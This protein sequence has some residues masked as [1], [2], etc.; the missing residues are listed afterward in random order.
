MIESVISKRA[1]CA[2]S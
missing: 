2:K 1:V